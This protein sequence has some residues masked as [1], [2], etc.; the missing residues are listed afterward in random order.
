MLGS[1]STKE[2]RWLDHVDTWRIKRWTGARSRWEERPRE[3]FGFILTAKVSQ[4]WGC[5]GFARKKVAITPELW[6]NDYS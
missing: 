4:D 1:R 3:E 6:K 5:S 2:A